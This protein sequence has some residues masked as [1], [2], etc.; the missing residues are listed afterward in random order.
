MPEHCEKRFTVF[1]ADI[2]NGGGWYPSKLI[3]DKVIYCP[4]CGK[5]LTADESISPAPKN[6]KRGQDHKLTGVDYGF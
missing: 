5:N 6:S 2:S 4:F 1:E 3:D